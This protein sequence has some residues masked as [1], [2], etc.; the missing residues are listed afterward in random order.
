MPKYKIGEVSHLLS[1][2]NDMLRYYESRGIVSPQ[3]DEQTGYRYYD[4][5]DLNFILDSKWLRSFDFSLSDVERMINKDDLEALIMSCRKREEEMLH[6]LYTYQQKLTALV[7]FRQRAERVKSE[8]GCLQSVTSPAFVYQ[9]ARFMYELEG[10]DETP[11][12]LKQWTDLMP[13]INHTFLIPL[14]PPSAQR[15]FDEYWWGYSLPP[16][17]AI[18]NN[19]RITPPAEYFPP[20]KSIRTVFSAGG[21]NTFMTSFNSQVLNV[22][23]EMGYTISHSPI[24]NLIA[25]VHEDGDFIRYFEIW[26]PIE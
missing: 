5:W 21:R 3:K 10:G 23:N 25:R 14:P 6:T 7:A 13:I 18:R 15:V 4:A 12:L 19:I 20:R 11:P 22:L 8:L 9:K 1:L 26:V 2:S 16:E 17:E 24:G